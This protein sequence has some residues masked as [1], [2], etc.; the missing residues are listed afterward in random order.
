MYGAGPEGQ[1]SA[2]ARTALD[3]SGA[4]AYYDPAQLAFA[5]QT[6]LDIG[7]GYYGS[8][9]S[10]DGRDGGSDPFAGAAVSLVAPFGG[11]LKGLAFGLYGL[12]PMDDLGRVVSRD[13]GT[14]QFLECDGL[15]RFALYAALAY[16]LGPVAAG[17]GVQLLDS[18]QGS[19]ALTE[20]LASASIPQ[21][22]LQLDL[23]PQASF[24]AG[25][26]WNATDWLR[27][28]AS[29]RG[30]S[31]VGV[32]LPSDVNL[33]PL[34][35]D[36]QLQALSFYRPPTWTLG[37]AYAGDAFSIDVDVSWLQWSQAPDPALGAQFT[38]SSPIL[39][40][41]ASG[42]TGVALSDEPVVRIGGE[43][44]LGGPFTLLAGYAYAPNP[45]PDQTGPTNL[46][47][48]DRHEVAAGILWSFPDLIG[49]STGPDALVLGGQYHVLVQRQVQ[50]SDPLD[51]YGDAVYG[52]SLW[53][54]GLTLI[55]R[56]GA[57]A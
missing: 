46:L 2:G 38:P 1:A 49:F 15:H 4:A 21:R 22:T 10:Y 19:L 50:K 41:L 53:Q 25:L 6:R 16:H 42:P 36:L 26:A 30:P 17:V 13:P 11:K 54:V 5:T 27:F 56:F 32:S 57:G 33:G 35:F 20:D 9:L 37:A 39:P 29:Y 52:G 24:D 34:A 14:P 3:R 48:C 8:S 7:A 12:F 18:A 47:D 51:L 45:V 28:G 31:Q 40:S 55:L 23:V 43:L 44:R